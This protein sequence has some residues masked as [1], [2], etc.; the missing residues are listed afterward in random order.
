MT[1]TT[2]RRIQE[3]PLVIGKNEVIPYTL[4]FAGFVPAAV[5][6]L[7]SPTCTLFDITAGEPGTDVSATKLTGSVT[8][9]GL[10]MTLKLITG[11]ADG[12]RYLLRCGGQGGGGTYELWGE[13]IGER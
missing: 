8:F 7:T 4:T 13:V 11:L 6:T 3:S 9:S 12:S 10:V 2:S 1:I 5:T